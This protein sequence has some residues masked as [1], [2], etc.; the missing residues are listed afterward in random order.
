LVCPSPCPVFSMPVVITVAIVI[1]AVVVLKSSSVAIPVPRVE[2]SSLITGTNP[3]GSFIRRPAPITGMP[4][5]TSALGIPVAI[6]PYVS[7]TRRLRSDSHY[8]R[9][10]RRTDVNSYPYINRSL[11]KKARTRS[12][13]GNQQKS[14]HS[15]SSRRRQPLP[16]SILC[17][18]LANIEQAR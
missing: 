17:T 16:F 13:N 15:L 2:L 1:P 12:Q 7:W 11:T 9:R 14:F 10:R 18:A 6:D 3:N 5:V 4:A 8:A